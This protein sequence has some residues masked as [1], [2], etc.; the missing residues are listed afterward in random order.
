M[1]EPEVMARLVVKVVL[2]DEHRIPPDVVVSPGYG[3][4]SKSWMVPIY[5]LSRRDLVIPPDEQLVPP[6]GVSHP[7]PPHAPRWMG[8]MGIANRAPAAHSEVGD[9]PMG[10]VQN[11]PVDGEMVE[12]V[13]NFRAG[14]DNVAPMGNIYFAI[15]STGAVGVDVDKVGASATS[16]EIVCDAVTSDK[17][18]LDATTDAEDPILDKVGML[19]LLL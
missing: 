16:K 15:P 2:H 8:P 5:V 3:R 14:Q 4:G 7:L 19:L 18:I 6:H 10:D 11:N 9:A 17:R 12:P 13:P 1:H